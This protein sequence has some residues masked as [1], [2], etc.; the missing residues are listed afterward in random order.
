MTNSARW[1]VAAIAVAIGSA[2][3]GGDSIDGV[4]PPAVSSVTPPTQ[5]G[6]PAPPS[7]ATPDMP[8]S[9]PA[10]AA[11][12]LKLTQYVDPMIGTDQVPPL[13][14][15]IAGTQ[16]PPEDLLGGFT[17]PAA[18]MPFGMV[19]WGP[20]T[21]AV[22]NTW[23]PPGYHYS[24]TKITGFSLT[25]LSGVGCYAG[26]ALPVLPMVE[27][28][29]GPAEFKHINETVRP[30]YYG[31]TFDNGIRTELSATQRSGVARFVWPAG[32]RGQ[33]NLTAQTSSVP[34]G[35]GAIAL[36]PNDPQALSGSMQGGSFCGNGQNYTIYFYARVDRPFAAEI[37]GRSAVLSF[38]S[39]SGARSTVNMKVGIS[40][41]SVANAKANLDTESGT[42][43]LDQIAA[44]ADAVWNKE[45][46]VIQVTGGSAAN[47]KKFYTSLYHVL[48]APS[49]FSDVNG[50]YLTMDGK[51]ANA[52]KGRIVVV[53]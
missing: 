20:D 41:V 31:V 38:A 6:V 17:S 2:G 29:S 5:P 48:L 50:D 51:I 18:T 52:G 11:V 37:N 53:N 24:Q 36:E 28:Q 19:Q 39:S 42:Q 26:G 8:A 9:A 47:L 44:Q 27:G 32:Q 22:P 1:I 30:G 40:Y 25:H 7:G 13:V 16:S 4:S 10:A 35:S 3:C 43:T 33:L 46:N 14:A 49:V 23:S 21:P 15:D 45:L 34:S 12:D